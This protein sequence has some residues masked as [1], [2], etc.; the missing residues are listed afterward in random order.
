MAILSL[1]R[2]KIE[3]L[4]EQRGQKKAEVN[5]LSKLSTEDMW[6]SD[7]NDFEIE[8]NK[9]LVEDEDLAAKADTTKEKV[10]GSKLAGKTKDV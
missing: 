2:E 8:W 6:Q 10:E 7:L 5:T 4:H 9:L 1:T 3:K